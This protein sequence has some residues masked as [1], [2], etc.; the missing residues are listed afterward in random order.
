MALNNGTDAVGMWNP[1]NGA[2]LLINQNASVAPEV[3]FICGA[4]SS[5][6]SPLAGKW[7]PGGSG[8]ATG[9][10]LTPEV[11]PTFAP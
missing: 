5:N 8:G 11:A 4:G 3:S 9:F 6:L 1:A 2:W 10:E 7:T